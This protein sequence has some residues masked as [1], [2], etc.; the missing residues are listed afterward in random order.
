[1]Q[2]N[3]ER[4]HGSLRHDAPRGA[5]MVVT[6]CCNVG[7]YLFTRH[8]SKCTVY[9]S[10]LDLFLQTLRR[11]FPDVFDV[12]TVG[13]GDSRPKVFERG[14]LRRV[15]SYVV[16]PLPGQVCRE[17]SINNVNMIQEADHRVSLRWVHLGIDL[18]EFGEELLVGP[19]FVLEERTK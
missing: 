10:K 15:S 14:G 6:V 3:R 13:G 8:A 1:M 2:I 17:D 12:P 11:H 16:V 4:L 7:Q 9:E 5:A 18:C 19:G